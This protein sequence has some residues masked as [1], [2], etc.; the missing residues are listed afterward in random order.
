[1]WIKLLRQAWKQEIFNN[2]KLAGILALSISVLSFDLR[3][4]GISEPA[5]Y[6]LLAHTG[7]ALSNAVKDWRLPT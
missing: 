4:Q 1:M 7:A 2:V 6:S 3:A 5:L